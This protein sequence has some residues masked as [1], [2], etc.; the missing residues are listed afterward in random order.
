[1]SNIGENFIPLFKYSVP[2]DPAHPNT[3]FNKYIPA[4]VNSDGTTSSALYYLDNNGNIAGNYFIKHG[5]SSSDTDAIDM[6]LAPALNSNSYV[7]KNQ[8]YL[9]NG[10]TYDRQRNNTAVNLTGLPVTLTTL[11]N[12]YNS[13]TIINYNARTLTLMLN[14]ANIVGN[15]TLAFNIFGLE[16]T[17]VIANGSYLQ[18]NLTPAMNGSYAV[19][20]FNGV[21]N[22]VTKPDIPL[23]FKYFFVNISISGVG[24]SLQIIRAQMNLG[25]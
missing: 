20:F 23:I 22:G 4:K 10:A 24:A 7:F 18:N 11:N 25:V 2:I 14:I 15:P 3:I 13:G 19:G 8:N 16:N 21:N 1:M 12:V 5:D 6:T 17:N 9:F